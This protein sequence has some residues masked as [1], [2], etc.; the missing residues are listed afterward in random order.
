MKPE[1]F[2]EAANPSGRSRTTR[3]P[4]AWAGSAALVLAPAVQRRMAEVTKRLT[5]GET[6]LC[7]AP[8]VQSLI[9]PS[10]RNGLRGLY[11][12][13]RCKRLGSGSQREA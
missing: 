6:S 10:I 1:K 2:G 12:K 4:G 11:L 8:R 3:L 13:G 7:I 9:R 5:T